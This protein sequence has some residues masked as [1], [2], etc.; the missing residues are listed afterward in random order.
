MRPRRRRQLAR[1]GLALLGLSLGLGL[2]ELLARQH[3]GSGVESLVYGAPEGV[4]PEAYQGD[5]ALFQVPTPG[6]SGTVRGVEYRTELRF[7]ALGLR[8]AG[9]VERP[10]ALLLGDS[11]ALAAQ[12]SEAESLAGQLAERLGGAVLNAG[13]DGYSTWQAAGRYERLRAEIDPERVILLFFLG[14][15]LADNERFPMI[16]GQRYTPHPRPEPGWTDRSVLFAFARVAWR[17][18]AI[19]QGSPERERFRREL[20]PFSEQGRATLEAQLP[21]TEAALTALRDAAARAGDPLL[22]VVAPPSFALDPERAASTL[23][24]VGLD[25]ARAALSAP[26]QAVLGL[27]ARL[28]VAACDLGPPLARTEGAWLTFDGHWTPAGNAA[29]AAAVADC[30]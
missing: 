12:V 2:A 3:S 11:F 23:G 6:W 17:A 24:L 20:E 29:A 15:D 5:D 8:G 10:A 9:G 30:L 14:N 19:A 4:P 7:D 18:R 22:V 27:L 28:G 26:G 1:L 13:V 16:R 21:A 25:P